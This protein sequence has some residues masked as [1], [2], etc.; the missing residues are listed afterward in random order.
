V[1]LLRCALRDGRGGE[2]GGVEGLVESAGSVVDGDVDDGEPV[3]N[4]TDRSPKT[5]AVTDSSPSTLGVSVA[6]SAGQDRWSARASRGTAPLTGARFGFTPP[7]RP[8][9]AR[10]P[11]PVA[12]VRPHGPSVGSPRRIRTRI[13]SG[14]SSQPGSTRPVSAS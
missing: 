7:T 12:V 3:R 11:A 4:T 13:R 5:V 9:H 6:L 10:S 1:S 2:E 8:E 14:M